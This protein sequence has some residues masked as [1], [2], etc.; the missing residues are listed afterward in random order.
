MFGK[1][2]QPP[3]AVTLRRLTKEERRQV[4]AELQKAG[5]NRA[6]ARDRARASRAE[7]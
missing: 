2:K 5:L 1:K 6:Q 3:K 4:Q 7:V